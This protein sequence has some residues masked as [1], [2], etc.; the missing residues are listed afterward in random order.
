MIST[1]QMGAIGKVGK[2]NYE[3]TIF[4]DGCAKIHNLRE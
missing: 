3:I 2:Y 4:Q 1:P